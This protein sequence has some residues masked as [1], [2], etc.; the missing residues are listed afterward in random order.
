MKV[1]IDIVEIE[2]IEKSIIESAEF[3]NKLLYPDELLGQN[4]ESICGK[5]AAKEAIIKTGYIQPG[6]W[7]KVRI[8][9]FDSGKPQVRDEHNNPLSG[10]EISI[11]HT[12]N[13]AVAVA[14]Y[15]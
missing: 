12:G 2:R 3:L 14:I 5:I 10:L 9:H 8:T 1:G 11:T 7:K 15:E 4:L 13:L 6:E